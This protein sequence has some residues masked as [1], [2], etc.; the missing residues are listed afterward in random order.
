MRDAVVAVLADDLGQRCR[1]LEPRLG[2]LDRLQ[3]DRLLNPIAAEAEPLTD[4]RRRG[5]EVGAA[6]R[7]V[8]VAPAPVLSPPGGGGRRAYQCTPFM[9]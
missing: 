7:A 2:Q 5:L 3:R 1:R 8:L 4:P 6:E 9:R